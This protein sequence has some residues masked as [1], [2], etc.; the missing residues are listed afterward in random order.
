MGPKSYLSMCAP[1][2]VFIFLY[3]QCDRMRI[4]AC[5]LQYHMVYKCGNWSSPTHFL[6]FMS[7]V[8]N[9]LY[10]F[11]FILT[12]LCISPLLSCHST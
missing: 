7:R 4:Y 12:E 6:L 10:L 5:V 9:T 1:M 8:H 2:R 11:H 3:S